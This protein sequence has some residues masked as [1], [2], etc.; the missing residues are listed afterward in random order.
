MKGLQIS[1]IAIKPG[2]AHINDTTITHRNPVGR[3]G[4]IP[5]IQKNKRWIFTLHHKW[6]I[7]LEAHFEDNHVEE[8]EITPE[9]ECTI[10]QIDD[11]CLEIA[12]TINKSTGFKYFK[13]NLEIL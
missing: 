13:Y 1:W 9:R 7:L 8:Y 10:A 4:T 2:D 5:L 12:N 11:Q 3:V 6:Q